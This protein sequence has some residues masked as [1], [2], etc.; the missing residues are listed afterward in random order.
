V[1]K[2]TKRGAST[3]TSGPFRWSKGWEFDD[4]ADQKVPGRQ[5]PVVH[6]R[7]RQG[8]GEFET[9]LPS[10]DRINDKIA[11]EWW[12]GKIQAHRQ[13]AV[14]GLPDYDKD[15]NL[16]DYTDMFVSSPDALWQLPK[17]VEFWESAALDL[18]PISA[19]IKHDLERLAAVL[20]VPLHTI[21]PDA[22]AG[23]AEGASL[24]REEH[25]FKVEDRRDRVSGSWARVMELM[26]LFDGDSQR[27]DRTKIEPLWGPVE[28]YS[29]TEKASAAAQASGS[30]PVEAIQTDIWQY[31]P[32]EIQN[33]RT[34]RGR[35]LLF[36]TPPA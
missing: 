28:R 22:A 30:L 34:L 33:L 10:L 21:T 1:R 15:G 20:S 2:A 24:M 29:L 32:A 35:D 26:F 13:R 19:S 7:N 4:S 6:F 16:I 25:V 11:N 5:I 18:T 14:K 27:A 12:I 3:V 31:P 36:K 17:D 8:W 9:H 23:S